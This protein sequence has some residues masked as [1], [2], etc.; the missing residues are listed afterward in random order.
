MNHDSIH[1]ELSNEFDQFQTLLLCQKLFVNKNGAH[2]LPKNVMQLICLYFLAPFQALNQYTPL[3]DL[4]E[5]LRLYLRMKREGVTVSD[6]HLEEIETAQASILPA[7][8]TLEKVLHGQLRTNL[9]KH[10]YDI[11]HAF[12]RGFRLQYNYSL[13]FLSHKGQIP[14]P[15]ASLFIEMGA[16]SYHDVD[17]DG[18]T[19]LHRLIG[20]NNIFTCRKNVKRAVETIGID[21][22]LKDKDGK[23]ARDYESE[24]DAGRKKVIDY[25]KQA[26]EEEP[27]R[28]IR[29]LFN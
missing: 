21:P 10:F 1:K 20:N 29:S 26:E 18:K 17:N 25:L 15:Y 23:T 19:Y 12:D 11:Y 6:Q 8:E 2:I 13:L 5:N 22:T 27:I 4:E 9:K 28:C 14:N 24:K 7:I 16:A 3:V